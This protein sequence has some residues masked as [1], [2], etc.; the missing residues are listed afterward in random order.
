MCTQTM[1]VELL[2]DLVVDIFSP[3][4]YKIEF[5]VKAAIFDL[6]TD[7]DLVVG[8]I[9]NLNFINLLAKLAVQHFHKLL[10]I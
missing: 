5:E 6:A 3:T 8:P 10:K 9:T 2:R 1:S 7:L 4:S